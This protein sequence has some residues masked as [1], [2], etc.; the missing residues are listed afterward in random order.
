MAKKLYL[1]FFFI[2]IFLFYFFISLPYYSGDVKNHVVWAGSI[3][4]DGTVG[5][6]DRTF[7]GFAYQN[8]PSLAMYFFAGSLG[9]YDLVNGSILNLNN[10]SF[11]PSSLVPFF[12]WENIRVSFLKLPGF[13]PVLGIS[14]VIYFFACSYLKD[15]LSK[16]ILLMALF[17]FNPAVIYLGAV[18]GQ[19]DLLPLMFILWA[20]YFVLKKKLFLSVLFSSFALLSKQTII[21]FWLIYLILLYKQ[22]DIKSVVK[23]LIGNF[24]IFQLS[25]LPFGLTF[26]IGPLELYKT[27]YTL[28][29][30]TTSINALNF[31]ALFFGPEGADD[32]VK[33]FGISYQY[34]GYIIFGIFF[35][36]FLV[37]FIKSKITLKNF[38]MFLFMVTI[39]YYLFL[40]RMHERYIIPAVVFASLFLMF[41]KKYWFNYIF[42]TVLAFLNIY[43]GLY[44]PSIG[45]L[46]V[47]LKNIYFLNT[48]IILYLIFFMINCYIYFFKQVK[49]E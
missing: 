23:A 20:Y 39:T 24:L 9:L 13:L 8:Y 37:R 32:R 31:W 48:L 44:Q 25:Y 19:I 27:N 35:I 7:P 45:F 22:M 29:D 38:L 14:A 4:S 40:T 1:G 33:L 17:A 43:R 28:V 41:N 34:L 36:S 42:I 3:L 2:F 30:S 6:F 21:I 26:L 10:L 16:K 47:A 18:W 5:F 46:E 15:K 49:D 11:F 12:A